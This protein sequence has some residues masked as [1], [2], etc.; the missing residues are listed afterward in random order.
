MGV[1]KTLDKIKLL[2]TELI[3]IRTQNTLAM[4]SAQHKSCF[5]KMWFIILLSWANKDDLVSLT[6]Y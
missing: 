5:G 2:K 3:S 1:E 6:Q 4:I